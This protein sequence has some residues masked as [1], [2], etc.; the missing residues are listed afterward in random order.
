MYPEHV[1]HQVE[2]D[3]CNSPSHSY[4]DMTSLH[5]LRTKPVQAEVAQTIMSGRADWP[6]P[7][8]ICWLDNLSAFKAQGYAET[9]VS[10]SLARPGPPK[11]NRKGATGRLLVASCRVKK[12]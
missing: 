3:S 11:P 2:P 12:R 6:T 4:P 5:E 9:I 7:I 10:G 8:Y 1:L